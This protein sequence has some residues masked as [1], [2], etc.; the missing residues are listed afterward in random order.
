MVILMKKYLSFVLICFILTACLPAQSPLSQ[1]SQ[2]R[3]PLEDCTLSMAGLNVSI[4][5]RCGTYTV[6]ED[7]SQAA[8]RK[9]AL[10]VAVVPAIS[11]TPKTDPVF[12][13]VGGPGQAAVELYPALSFSFDR[14]QKDR[15][16]V[17]VDQRGTGK[18]NPLKCKFPED[19]DAELNE[20]E[21]LDIL[22]GCPQTL[23]ADLRFYTTDIAMQDLDE[24]RAT[25]GYQQ[26][27]LYGVSYGTRAAQAYL[28]LFPDHVRSMTLDAIT[29]TD[30]RIFLTASQDGQHALN[31]MFERCKA[32]ADCTAAFPNLSSEFSELLSRLEKQPADIS[33]TH[34]L[35]G[36][37]LK[38]KLTRNILRNGV[39]AQLYSAEMV[40]LLPL[41]LHTA[42]KENNF[43]PFVNQMLSSDMGIYNGLLYTVTCAEDAPRISAEQAAQAADGS[44]FGD[45]SLT[46][47]TV[48]PAWPKVQIP[49]DFYKPVNSS[50]PTL[51]FSGQADPITPPVYAQK[52]AAGLPNSLHLI[53]PGMGHGQLSRPC[54]TRIFTD[55]VQ[56]G[57][58]AGLDTACFG[59][60]KPSPFFISFTGPK[61]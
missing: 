29:D 28:R 50:V 51:L 57:S 58:T 60:M 11:R 32:D 49:A 8:G 48:C 24:V 21:V 14:L 45:M 15:D 35:T 46:L 22:K 30:F 40:S 2:P 19:E 17:L 25:L 1:A 7:R 16:I 44:V 4:K 52:V 31:L 27:N 38:F 33:I 9:I 3:L 56:Q 55:F 37:P 6:P 59:Q 13:L 39:Y 42:A 10:N 5:A 41:A 23:D 34:P 12:I 18:S 43:A 47:R 26:I 20:Q 36:K 53:A 54:A 61:P